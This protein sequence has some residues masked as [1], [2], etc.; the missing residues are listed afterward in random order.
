MV[1]KANGSKSFLLGLA[2]GGTLLSAALLYR[3]YT[4]DAKPVKPRQQLLDDLKAA[5]LTDVQKSAKN[6]L[7][8]AEYF[9]KLL[10]YIGKTQ[11]EQL[12]AIRD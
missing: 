8:S 10:Q 5:E 3:Y 6:T 7:I 2:A 12:K 4:S 1:E 11:C 9:L